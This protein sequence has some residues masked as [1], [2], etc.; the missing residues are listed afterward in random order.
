MNST[1]KLELMDCM[2]MRDEMQLTILLV[3]HDMQLVMNTCEQIAVLN[4]GR[5]ISEGIM[6]L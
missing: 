2:K 3:E 5:K 6:R 4:Y 1:E